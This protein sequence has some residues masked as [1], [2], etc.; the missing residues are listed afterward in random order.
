MVDF[1]FGRRA[2]PSWLRGQGLEGRSK[3]EEGRGK[4]DDGRRL[5]TMVEVHP[6]PHNCLRSTSRLPCGS[7]PRLNPEVTLR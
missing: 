5:M 1:P 6:E 3:M 2:K 4:R 7:E